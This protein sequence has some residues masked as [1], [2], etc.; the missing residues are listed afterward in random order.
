MLGLDASNVVLSR[1]T[2]VRNYFAS[3]TVYIATPALLRHY[4]ISPGAI[5]G[6]SLFITSRPGLAGLSGLRMLYGDFQ[7]PN[8]IV[9]NIANPTIQQISKLPT[10]VDDPNLLVT[11]HAV[12]ELKLQVI[13][14]GWLIQTPHPLT[15]LQVEIAR[16]DAVA[17]RLTIET[18]NDDP[19]LSTVRNDAT[20]AGIIIALGVLAMTVGLI[21]TE[22][23]GDLRT[24]TATGANRRIRRTLTAATAGALGLLGAV[25]GT[26]VAF[27]AAGAF[28]WAELA[29]LV[30]KLP[31][32]DL[33]LI[34]VG[35]PVV[36]AVGG[37]I[38]AGREP[39]NIS[40][41]PLE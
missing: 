11:T 15:A 40:H 27:L 17:A 34:L 5:N 18:K 4:A 6:D 14:A 41:Q 8:G 26:A 19:S 25:L 36:A 2:L 31:A 30:S 16:R 37:W 10:D 20:A 24:L 7:S 13:Q 32:L 9:H 21:R 22:A 29:Q 23:A 39:E 38:F 1:H 28:F 3:G 12:R 33:L 35:L